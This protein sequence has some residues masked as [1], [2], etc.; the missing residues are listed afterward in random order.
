MRR[1]T[2]TN[3]QKIEIQE[4]PIPEPDEG[5][6]ILR[7]A[8]AGVCGSD[9]H[10]F[11]GTNPIA[12]LPRVQGH[13]FCGEIHS[14]GA[15][16]YPQLVGR[17]VAV[18]PLIT[19]GACPACMDG[20]SHVCRSLIVIGVN[21]DGGFGE[22]VRLPA[23]NVLPI[24]AELPDKVAVLTEP[25]S[26]GYHS[27]SRGR[28]TAGES[29]L[30]VGAGPIGLYAA[31]VARA[32]GA[33]KVIVSEIAEPRQ[34]VA[35]SFGFEVVDPSCPD[36]LETLIDLTGGKGVPIVVETSGTKGGLDTAQKAAAISGRIVLLGFPSDRKLP[37]DITL[38]IVKEL[39]LI[40][41]R[42]CPR[43]EFQ[44]TLDLLQK[45]YR[46]E[47]AQFDTIIAGTYPLSG[48]SEAIE[49]TAVANSPGK[50]LI[51]PRAT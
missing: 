30:I 24:A 19:C 2:L 15:S 9:V 37:Y 29:V 41:S 1:A 28:F 13:E 4:A 35:R 10:I 14:V 8:F 45:L 6:V 3:W 44:A 42:V 18:H 49:K 33:G 32:L 51:D 27:L 43:H 34:S 39:E 36:H 25:F 17:R 23:G 48:V 16:V 38:A 46:E 5:E 21:Q 7:T 26:I 31:I 12:T 11:K 20:R 47:P 22:Y 50:L 40:G